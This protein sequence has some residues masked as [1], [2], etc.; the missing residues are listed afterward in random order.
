MK[1][2]INN[3]LADT[4]ACVYSPFQYGGHADVFTFNPLADACIQTDLQNKAIRQRMLLNA[5]KC[6]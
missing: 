6:K 1:N 2:Q 3:L 4:I 5:N